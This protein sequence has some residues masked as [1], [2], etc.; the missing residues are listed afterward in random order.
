MTQRGAPRSRAV[1]LV[2]M[3]VWAGTAS[4]Q[5]RAVTD[6]ATPGAR[7]AASGLYRLMFGSSYRDLW[8]TPVEVEVLDLRAVGGGLTPTGTGGGSQTLNLRFVGADGLPYTFRGLDKDPTSILPE[9]LQETFAADIVQD[10]VHAAFPTAPPVVEVFLEAADLVPRGSRIVIMPNDTLLGE[11]REQ[12]AGRIGT[13]ETWAN[14]RTGNVAGFA[15]AT[16]VVSTDELSALLLA[17]PHEQVDL[18]S[19][20][21]ARLLDIFV[22]DWDRHRGQWRWGNVGPGDPPSWVPFPEDRDQA[23][24]R[25]DGLLLKLAGQLSPQLTTF[26]GKYSPIGGAAWNGRDIDRWL[27]PRIDKATWDSTAQALQGILTAELIDEAVRTLPAAHYALRGDFLRES[28]LQRRDNFLEMAEDY[29]R[30]LAFQVDLDL[31]DV[32]EIVEATRNDDGSIALAVYAAPDGVPEIEPYLRRHFSNT[33]TREIRIHLNGG[34]DA[35][36]VRGAGGGVVLRVLSE[37]GVNTIVDTASGRRTYV[38]DDRVDSLLVVGRGVDLDDRHWVAP[39]PAPGEL[40]TRDW[41]SMSYPLAWVQWSPDLGFTIVGGYEYKRFGFRKQPFAQ[42]HTI[43][44]AFSVK[45]LGVRANYQGTLVHEGSGDE[46]GIDLLASGIEINNFYGFGN[47]TISGG[48]RDFFKVDQN[49]FRLNLEFRPTLGRT[50]RGIMGLTGRFTTTSEDDTT[51]VVA[52]QPYGIEDYT[53]IGARIGLTFDTRHQRVSPSSGLWGELI[54]TAYPGILSAADSG[55]FGEMHGLVEGYVMPAR[56]LTLGLRA[57]GQRVWGTFPF[58]ESAFI[59]GPTSL[60][61]YR[62]QRFAGEASIFAQGT[63]RLH[64][65]EVFALVPS[66]V[67]LVGILDAGRVWYQSVSTGGLHWG[68]GGGIYFAPLKIPRNAFV[69]GLAGGDDGTVVYFQ[70]GFAY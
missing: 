4:A 35:V 16:E 6:T 38:Y 55:A 1:W 24:A 40:P 8:T 14:E 56:Q 51:L 15:G 37:E 9:E 30:H 44:A 43:Q 12:F 61:G 32:A 48:E 65:A 41:G 28:L 29:Y 18:T 59:G 70:F 62:D 2:L 50:F 60:R 34:D 67:G 66:H 20:L 10:Q 45:K 47:S 64:L 5:Q 11:Y 17:D 53:E 46:F 39:E 54:G 31:T 58:Q 19:F 33:Y 22:G 21:E 3:M 52:T 26:G 42:R 13:I 36:V 63:V 49:D 7:Y 57:G 23:F 27:F 69:L 68:Y 25:Y